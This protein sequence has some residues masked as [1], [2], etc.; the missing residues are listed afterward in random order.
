MKGLAYGLKKDLASQ[1]IFM[2]PFMFGNIMIHMLDAK[3]IKLF[4]QVLQ[5]NYESWVFQKALALSKDRKDQIKNY[6]HC[7]TVLFDMTFL[8]FMWIFKM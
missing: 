1:R 5:R 4:H 7:L 3:E 6:T 2:F 8:W